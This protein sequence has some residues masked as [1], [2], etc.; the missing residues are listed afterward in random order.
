MCICYAVCAN[1]SQV[2]TFMETQ[3]TLQSGGVGKLRECTSGVCE[4]LRRSMQNQEPGT[5]GGSR[6]GR[7]RNNGEKEREKDEKKNCI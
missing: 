1:S 5:K 4:Y 7:I 6:R 3:K 2:H